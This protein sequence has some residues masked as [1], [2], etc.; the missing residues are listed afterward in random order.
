[1]GSRDDTRHVPPKTGE[2]GQLSREGSF[3]ESK[4]PDEPEKP[5]YSTAIFMRLG[6][7]K[8]LK[9]T[10]SQTIA[11]CSATI[12][13]SQSKLC[14][15]RTLT[16]WGTI[17]TISGF[18]FAGRSIGKCTMEGYTQFRWKSFQRVVERKAS[19]ARDGGNLCAKIA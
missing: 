12:S 13:P 3:A 15:G 11:V 10:G 5:C 8:S 17:V 14:R 19:T 16:Q 1:M 6:I 7:N 4:E 9:L 2:K 18:G